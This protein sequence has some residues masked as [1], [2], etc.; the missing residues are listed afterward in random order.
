MVCVDENHQK[1][2]IKALKTI[3][4][5]V[6]NMPKEQGIDTNTDELLDI[7]NQ[8]KDDLLGDYDKFLT[9]FNNRASDIRA[10]YSHFFDRLKDQIIA[11]V[12]S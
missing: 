6:R 4:E 12:K 10:K 1:H 11:K 2:P 3:F 7:V 5:S 8:S 9:D